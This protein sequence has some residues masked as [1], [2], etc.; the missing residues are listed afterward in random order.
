MLT[1]DEWVGPKQDALGGRAPP[2]S[3]LATGYTAQARAAK[4]GQQPACSGAGAPEHV[5]VVLH[6]VERQELVDLRPRAGVSP[7]GSAGTRLVQ[8]EGAL[9]V[10]GQSAPPPRTRRR[11]APTPCPAPRRAP[12]PGP[13]SLDRAYTPAPTAPGSPARA[14]HLLHR[15]LVV[16]VAGGPLKPARGR[17]APS[18]APRAPRA[19]RGDEAQQR[20]GSTAA[21]G[22]RALA[23]PGAA[24]SLGS[25]YGSGRTSA[26]D[27]GAS[28]GPSSACGAAVAMAVRQRSA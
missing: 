20:P 19:A 16:H 15:L 24:H 4:H 12:N 9:W 21:L 18:A 5:V 14:A 28:M 8:P 10:S 1:C 2:S 23:A 6:V 11:R 25:A 3:A 22:V 17:A 13:R 7:T 27:L 26:T